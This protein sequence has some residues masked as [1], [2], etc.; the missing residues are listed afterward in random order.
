MKQ[1]Y[2][3]LPEQY[4]LNKK[5]KI[6]HSY[7][8]EQFFDYK[9]IFSKIEKIVK[10]GD[11]TLGKEVNKPCL[12]EGDM[13]GEASIVECMKESKNIQGCAWTPSIVM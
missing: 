12:H 3:Y 4:E 7:L 9:K 8:V 10:Q 6:N 11:Y 2:N 13:C 1:K 5:H